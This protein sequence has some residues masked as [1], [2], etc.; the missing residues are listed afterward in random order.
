MEALAFKLIF[1]RIENFF[2]AE[3]CL[4]I[5][6]HLMRSLCRIG[7]MLDSKRSFAFNLAVQGGKYLPMPASKFNGIYRNSLFKFVLPQNE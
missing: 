6:K 5:S 7:Q 1:H 3:I 2:Q 4:P